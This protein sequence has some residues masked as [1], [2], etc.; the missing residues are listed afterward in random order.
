MLLKKTICREGENVNFVALV[1]CT[2]VFKDSNYFRSFNQ[3]IEVFETVPV[4]SVRR[5]TFLSQQNH[6][7]CSDKFIYSNFSILEK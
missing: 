6:T 5:S 4:I 7:I 2:R 3:H 1:K